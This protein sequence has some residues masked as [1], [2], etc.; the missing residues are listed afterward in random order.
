MGL[1][2]QA[3][4]PCKLEVS[5]SS[6]QPST[7]MECIDIPK[8][9]YPSRAGRPMDEIPVELEEFHYKHGQ[10]AKRIERI[11]QVHYCGVI[12]AFSMLLYLMGVVWALSLGKVT[13]FLQS[14]TFTIGTFALCIALATI[15]WFESSF[16]TI[17]WRIR[18][19][20]SLSDQDYAREI[21]LLMR[22]VYSGRWHLLFSVVC[23]GL[24]LWSIVT[25]IAY[26][27]ESFWPGISV[28]LMRADFFFLYVLI[29]SLVGSVIVG[30][31]AKLGFYVPICAYRT[32]RRL[33][34]SFDF[35]HPDGI[36]GLAPLTNFYVKI[37]ALY[38]L[39]ASLV[40]GVF[41]TLFSFGSFGFIALV[42]FPG[43][44]GSLVFG[45]ALHG[46]IADS[47]E[48]LL[49]E[50]HEPITILLDCL[51]LRANPSPSLVQLTNIEAL[52]LMYREVREKSP[53]PLN[54]S[55]FGKA[56]GLAA[57][58]TLTLLLKIALQ[59]MLPS[60]QL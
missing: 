46:S 35:S 30:W 25:F 53:W 38:F 23:F 60:A 2:G 7:S 20:F 40:T 22:H 57:S 31:V 18:K 12:V 5:L 15:A 59:F 3:L 51:K 54:V 36:L 49:R 10:F 27:R 1:I 34:F 21:S 43:V 17:M 9:L 37:V 19:C 52:I 6:Y 56:L 4:T 16:M 33:P 44:F 28:N 55:L 14:W 13:E 11:F 32:I 29:W 8:A 45:Y 24:P 39:D 48:D 26:R 42:T 47:R 58:P 41:V 50:L